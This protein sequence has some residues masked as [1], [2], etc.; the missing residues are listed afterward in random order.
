MI[1]MLYCFDID[2]V[3]TNTGENIDPD[4]KEWFLEWT[5]DKSY[6]LIT[7]STYERTLEQ[8]GEEITNRAMLV[9][10]CMGN[11]IT[12]EGRTVTLNEFEFTLEEEQFL[13]DKLESS[14]YPE[15]AGTHIALRPGSVNFSIVGREAT[16]E[17]REKYKHYDS[18]EQERLSIA[19]QFKEKFPRFDVFIGGDISI[20]ICLRGANKRQICDLICN[21]WPEADILFY[22]DKMDQWGI[23][24]PLADEIAKRSCG[25][26][27]HIADGYKQ[28]R[29]ELS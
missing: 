13:L 17:Q 4:F 29:D 14:P 3:L 25:G 19:Q 7:G 23:D 15:R 5:Y 9:A 22:G 18:V 21:Y 11:S 16:T 28:T 1:R 24:T 2:G 10:N 12:Q 6:V 26:S 20:D 27:F 8:V